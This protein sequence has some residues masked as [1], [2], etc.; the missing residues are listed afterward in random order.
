ML[1]QVFLAHTGFAVR[2]PYRDSS[3]PAVVRAHLVAWQDDVTTHVALRAG[4]QCELTFCDVLI[5][6]GLVSNK[7]AKPTKLQ[8]EKK[9]MSCEQIETRH[10]YVKGRMRWQNAQETLR[11]VFAVWINRLKRW[12]WYEMPHW[13]D[14]LKRPRWS[15]LVP[16]PVACFGWFIYSRF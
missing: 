16:A 9:D 6:A 13:S 15:T 1:A 7:G 2:T 11:C 12:P 14:D 8:M 5:H 3:T 10:R 4:S